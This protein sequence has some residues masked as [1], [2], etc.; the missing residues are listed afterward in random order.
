MQ[1]RQQPATPV[2]QALIN[3]SLLM[4][5]DSISD[6]PMIDAAIAPQRSGIRVPYS[7]YLISI[8]SDRNP[9]SEHDQSLPLSC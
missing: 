3:A 7:P 8:V 5:A 9:I 1:Q 6:L 2:E 4:D